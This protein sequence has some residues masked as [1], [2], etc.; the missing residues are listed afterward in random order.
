[1]I[2]VRLSFKPVI[3]LIFLSFFCSQELKKVKEASTEVRMDKAPIKKEIPLI[4]FFGDSLT[5]GYG[6]EIDEA[7]PA[8]I[9]KKI[10]TS[11]KKY[12]YEVINAGRSGDTTAGGLERI[13]WVLQKIEKS[14][15]LS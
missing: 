7:P 10:R 1:M 8:L 14:V 12:N 6:L 9:A 15:I 2:K 3:L 13:D 5:A 11:Y 4:V